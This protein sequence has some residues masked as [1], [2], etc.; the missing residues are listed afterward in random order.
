[1]SSARPNRLR[2][3]AVAVIV[4]RGLALVAGCSSAEEQPEHDACDTYVKPGWMAEELR[5]RDEL[6][7]GQAACLTENDLTY[8]VL[9]GEGSSFAP[10]TDLESVRAIQTIRW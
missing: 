3:G 2:G 7:A 8:E 9:P 5:W 6:Q 4:T 1:M 10:G